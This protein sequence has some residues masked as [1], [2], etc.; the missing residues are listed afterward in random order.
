MI[1]NLLATTAVAV[2]LAGGAYAQDTTAPASPA[3]ATQAPV[4]APVT[5]AVGHLASNM[6]G[7]TVYNGTSDDAEN[8]GKVND[9]VI[10]PDGK[11]ESVVIG[12]GGFLGIG[13]K[14]VA[15]NYGEVEWAEQNG[16]RWLVVNT[17]KEQLQAQADFARRA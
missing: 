9:V 3:P 14:N 17:T 1:R 10:G 6:I 12:V 13:E 11:V 2:L 7:E 15:V 16:D 5:R 8:I 4:E